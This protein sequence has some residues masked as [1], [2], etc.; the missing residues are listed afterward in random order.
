[1]KIIHLA[2]QKEISFQRTTQYQQIEAFHSSSKEACINFVSKL[3]TKV[4]KNNRPV[5]P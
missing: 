1:M 5:R 4:R 3:S 2:R